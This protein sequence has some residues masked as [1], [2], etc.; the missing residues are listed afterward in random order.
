MEKSEE[1]RRKIN[2]LENMLKE[3]ITYHQ[4]ELVCSNKTTDDMI[5]IF[6]IGNIR[7]LLELLVN[8]R[9]LQY[10]HSIY[11]NIDVWMNPQRNRILVSKNEGV[12]EDNI[13]SFMTH[14]VGEWYV[15]NIN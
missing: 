2:E 4:Y 12:N 7:K 11:G 15:K 5:G 6:N 14:F 8:G 3:S 13:M 10:R 1:I 9:E